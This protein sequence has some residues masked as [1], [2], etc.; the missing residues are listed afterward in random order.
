MHHVKVSPTVSALDGTHI[1]LENKTLSRSCYWFI[2]VMYAFV[3]MTKCCYTAAMASMVSEGVLTKTQTGTITAAFYIIYG[4]LQLLGGIVSD[5]YNPYRMIKLSLIGATIA[6]TIIFFNHNYTV[7]LIAWCFN[8]LAQFSLW[9]CTFKIISSQL[10]RSDRKMMTFYISFGTSAGMFLSYL[11]AAFVSSWEYNFA[12]SAVVLLVFAIA[13]D[14]VYRFAMEPY[15]KP[16]RDVIVKNGKIEI[17]K[18]E[19]KNE[20]STLAIFWK[21]GFY[22]MCILVFL[23][24][25][26]DNG[27][28]TLTPTMLMEMYPGVSASYGNI[29]GVA[30]ILA[31]IVGMLLVRIVYPK[32][33]YSELLA[34]FLVLIV[35]LPFVLG[36]RLIGV[37]P[38]G[39]PVVMLCVA[40][41][42]F[43]AMRTFAYNY[44]LR[45]VEYGKSGTAAGV[46]NMAE[47]FAVTAQSY[48][49]VA[50]AENF[51]W[52]STMNVCC[53]AVVIAIVM[54]AITY[55]KWQKFK[56]ERIPLLHK[57]VKKK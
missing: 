43:T 33:I 31:G 13:T 7:M 21:T 35:A 55:A 23:R 53:I 51:G 8:A 10:V 14:M 2:W 47:S 18:T 54:N 39:Y 38:M 37:I 45:F 28:K 26:I 15:M 9:P 32:Y 34:H 24:V 57:F 6:N 25:V 19:S 42:L 12:I 5:K 46:S 56:G 27:I 17:E 52:N 22:S 50:I 30:V 41:A 16:D 49:F 48:G 4:P 1:H 11:V 3:Y 36:L 44:N 29:L 40:S 20:G